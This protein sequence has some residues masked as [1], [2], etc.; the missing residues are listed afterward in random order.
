LA[1][2][3]ARAVPGVETVEGR[4][5]SRRL[6]LAHGVASLSLDVRDDGA[7]VATDADARDVPDL[8]DR[9][10]AL[11]DLDADAPAIDRGLS[12]DSRLAA[13][14]AALPGVRSP[15]ILDREELVM[16]A[17]VGQQVS[18]AAARTV[19]GRLACDGLLP[20]A[21]ELAER[22]P[23]TLPM[24]RARA[25]A[26]VRAMEAVADDPSV[27]DDRE[28]LLALPG[29]GAWTADYIALRLGDRDAFLATDLHI[30]RRLA[31]ADPDRWRPYRAYALHRLWIGTTPR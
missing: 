4:R 21:G 14:V 23:E 28:R 27:V 1:F 18:V 11:L 25:R 9:V 13:H 8:I 17:I 20:P 12:S 19:L 30:V 6:R 5:Y 24:P 31:G 22:D 10:R 26:L 7:E 15:G 3:A 29:I 2:L 16:R